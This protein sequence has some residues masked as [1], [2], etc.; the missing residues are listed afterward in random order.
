MVDLVTIV[1]PLAG[2]AIADLVVCERLRCK[3]KRSACAARWGAARSN[4]GEACH[5]CPV[6]EANAGAGATQHQPLDLPGI[7]MVTT[8]LEEIRCTGPA[9]LVRYLGRP[10]PIRFRNQAWRLLNVLVA[11]GVA[12]RVPG[13]TFFRV[14]GETAEMPPPLVCDG[15]RAAL[16][17]RVIEAMRAHGSMSVGLAA[18]LLDIDPKAAR[19]A[20]RSLTRR[21]MIREAS[22]SSA[23]KTLWLLIW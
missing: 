14:V 6:G 16:Q 7:A 13:R 5:G 23:G 4:R 10:E 3:L 2:R 18:T 1:D 22:W 21:G 12:E 19:S 11:R 20:L 15:D 17:L 8:A 9:Q